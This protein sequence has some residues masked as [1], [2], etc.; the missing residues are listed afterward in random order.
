LRIFKIDGD[1]VF[2]ILKMFNQ[3]TWSFYE[4]YCAAVP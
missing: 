2:I 3:S 1:P 4:L